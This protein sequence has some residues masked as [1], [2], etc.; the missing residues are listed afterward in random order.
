MGAAQERRKKLKVAWI[1]S[2]A[3]KDAD[4]ASS[5][6]TGY[7]KPHHKM[8]QIKLIKEHRRVDGFGPRHS[9]FRCQTQ[10]YWELSQG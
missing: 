1:Q 3:I 9:A 6:D 2:N 8:H 10:R 7:H 4:K 5:E